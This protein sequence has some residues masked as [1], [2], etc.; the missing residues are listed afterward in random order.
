MSKRRLIV[1]GAGGH[2]K[3][4]VATL[5]AAGRTVDG[6]LDDSPT[7]VQGSVLGVPVI[8]STAYASKLG[9]CEAIIAVGD[10]KTRSLIAET[11]KLNWTVAVHPRAVVH[12]DVRIGTGTVVF[13]GAVIQPGTGIGA[14][15]I[16]NTGATVD[17][18]CTVGDFVH[19]APGSHLGGGVTIGNGAFV[20]IGA[21][22]LPN[23]HI[24]EWTVLGGGAVAIR[25]LCS[26]SIAVGVPATIIG[27]NTAAYGNDSLG[28]QHN[29]A[30]H[31][32]RIK[33]I[34]IGPDDPRWYGVLKHV[35]HDV[36]HLP[37]YVA[38]WCKH[39]GGQAL[40][41]YAEDGDEVCLIPLVRRQLPVKL[42]APHWWCDLVSPYGYPGP[43]YSRPE[44]T[45]RSKRFLDAFIVAANDLGACSVFLRLHPLINDEFRVPAALSSLTTQGATVA[46]DL[47]QTPEA[48][49]RQ[50]RSSHQY[51]IRRLERLKFTTV[52][53]DWSLYA[54]FIRMYRQTMSRIGA[55][56]DY[57]FPSQY[58]MDLKAALGD[59]LHLCCVISPEG[60]PAAGGLFTGAA[61]IM[62]YHL[63]GSDE[64]YHRLAPSK[65]MLHSMRLWAKQHGFTIFHLGGGVGSQQDSLFQF[66]AGF[67]DERHEFQTSRIVVNERRYAMLVLR[68][69]LPLDPDGDLKAR[70]FPPYLKEFQNTFLG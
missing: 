26:L 27:R 19:L 49:W 43:V 40:A 3:V 17:H 1:I 5:Q 7:L 58:F 46:I 62:Q 44:D 2:A 56:P 61:G 41:F 51:D 35:A 25:D 20:G 64:E 38:V 28:E 10:N 11:T 37:S 18:D 21:A 59:N 53:N 24:G 22:V 66:K 55:A 48:M 4:V 36:Y 8:G 39:Q 69:G 42:E 32:H 16:I 14:H 57:C 33:S 9:D 67:S 47:T 12:P 70:Y 52:T 31:I 63:S 13:A 23:R 60:R 6:I 30:Q 45:E 65:L 50:T 54:D 15:T 29:V 68:T 34:F